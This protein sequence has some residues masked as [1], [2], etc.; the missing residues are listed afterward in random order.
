MACHLRHLAKS[1]F[2]HWQLATTR[3]VS[4]LD[5]SSLGVQCQLYLPLMSFSCRGVYHFL[6][7]FVNPFGLIFAKPDPI[8]TKSTR[9]G[10]RICLIKFYAILRRMA[11]EAA[12]A[13]FATPS[14]SNRRR[15]CSLT[16]GM[17]MP[18]FTEMSLF[19]RPCVMSTRI[20]SSVFTLL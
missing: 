4:P 20:L 14:F 18:Y 11:R 12:S 17:A 1:E 7:P 6:P 13:R 16:V 5:A 8:T 19:V 9:T 15:M 10:W 3:P 2:Q